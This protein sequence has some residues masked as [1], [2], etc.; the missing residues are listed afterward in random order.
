MRRRRYDAA[1]EQSLTDVRDWIASEP[2]EATSPQ[3]VSEELREF[4]LVGDCGTVR[5]R[6]H[7][8]RIR[9]QHYLIYGVRMT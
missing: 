3:S 4:A 8:A 5:F 9:H 6:T 7:L 1:R 2:Q